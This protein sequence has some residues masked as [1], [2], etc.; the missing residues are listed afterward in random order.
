MKGPPV[1]PFGEAAAGRVAR[2]PGSRLRRLFGFVCEAHP[3][4]IYA[5]VCAGWAY[6]LLSMLLPPR[7]GAAL[8]IEGAAVALAFFLILLF[9]R[10]V[11]EVKDLDYDRRHNPMRPLVRGAVSLGEVWGLAA[12][13]AV[14]VL[15]LSAWLS[16]RLAVF[17]ALQMAY[18]IGL[19]LLERHSATFRR[20]I[21][22]NLCVTLPVSAALNVY[23][24]LFLASRGLA[25][26]LQQAVPVLLAHV[27]VFLHLEFGRKLKWPHLAA[28]GENGYALALGVPGASAACMLFGGAACALATWAHLSAGAGAASPLP[29]FA[30]L[31]AAVGLQGFIVSRQEAVSLKPY[32][33]GA[34]VLFFLINIAV[35]RLV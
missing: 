24:Y 16:P 25:P 15:A 2:V 26:P 30:L 32:F 33:G 4:P 7:A 29:W 35:A 12:A 8:G 23:A 9:L 31:P 22:L 17:A 34:M 21:L 3:P 13:V 1:P 10:A 5:V 18:G 19:L 20:R 27:A 11:D 28:A 6:S 14:V